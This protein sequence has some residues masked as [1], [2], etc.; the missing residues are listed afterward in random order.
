MKFS[1]LLRSLPLLV[2]PSLFAQTLD[3]S[4]LSWYKSRSGDTI[5]TDSSAHTV[6][7]GEGQ[8]SASTFITSFAPV[9]LGVGDMLTFDLSFTTGATLNSATSNS[10]RIGLFNSGATQVAANFNSNNNAAYTDD[11]GYA[12]SYNFDGT[13]GLGSFARSGV[14]PN[15]L[16]STTASGWVAVPDVAAGTKAALAASTTYTLTFTLA[17]SASG[18]VFTS[19]LNGGAISSYSRTATDTTSD[20]RNISAIDQLAIYV[21]GGSNAVSSLTFSSA[22]PEPST[23]ALLLGAGTIA[24]AGLRRWRGA[25]ARST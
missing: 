25:H 8:T 11:L 18:I 10:F 20:S 17:R 24:F 2:A 6:T 3:L 19:L 23:Y 15:T 13:N 12:L 16:L 5:T 7:L 1:T 21:N 22:I 9:S 4:A 14:L